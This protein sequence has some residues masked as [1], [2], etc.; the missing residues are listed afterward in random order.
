VST[1]QTRVRRAPD[2][3]REGSVVARLAATVREAGP[4]A[5]RLSRRRA[6]E[7]ALIG[8]PAGGTPEWWGPCWERGLDEGLSPAAR[9]DGLTASRPEVRVLHGLGVAG[10]T[11]VIDHVLVGPGGVVVADTE[12]C[13]GRVSSD[14][15]RLRVRGRDRSALIDLALWRAEVVRQALDT[16]GLG[17]APVHGVVHWDHARALGDGAVCLRGVP[18][19]TAGATVGLAAAGCALSPLTVDRVVGVLSTGLRER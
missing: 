12:T 11:V 14:G 17:D 15:V 1:A 2:E 7:A 8:F 10:T 4:G 5:R 19:L 6:V 16:R 9:I 13:P 3:A 18:L